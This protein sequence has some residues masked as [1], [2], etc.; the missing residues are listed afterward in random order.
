MLANYYKVTV[1]EKYLDQ[2][3][4]QMCKVQD[5]FLKQVKGCL[6]YQFSQDLKDRSVLYLFVVW[7]NKEEYEKNLDTEYQKKE[8]FDKFI[9]Y[10]AGI[11]SAEQFTISDMTEVA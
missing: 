4:P 7:K 2:V 5:H 9:E 1:P 6:K 8:I 3:I 10:N 11:I